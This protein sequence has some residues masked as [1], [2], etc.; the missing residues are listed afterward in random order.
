MIIFQKTV[1]DTASLTGVGVHSGKE[2]TM[3]IHPAPADHGIVFSRGDMGGEIT[4][5]ARVDYISNTSM[6][7]TLKNQGVSVG[8]VEHLLSALVGVGVDNALIVLTGGEVPIMDGSAYSFVEMIE[9]VGLQEQKQLRKFL[10]IKQEVTIKQGDKYATLK[11]FDGFKVSFKLEYDHH[12]F[13]DDNQTITLDFS[14]TSFTHE[15]AKARTFGFY[16]DY[17]KVKSLNLAQGASLDNT[18]VFSQDEIMNDEGLRYHD[19]MVRHKILDAIGDL[20]LLGHP[21]LASF[22]GFKSGHAVNQLLMEAV[23]QD[24]SNYELVTFGELKS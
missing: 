17:E 3:T 22:E 18:V 16:E 13:N 2:V 8:T 12:A 7:T 10:K 21:L 24:E 5:P 15:V 14:K 4:I 9:Q 1:A 20:Y 23:L 19:E 6:S 11:P